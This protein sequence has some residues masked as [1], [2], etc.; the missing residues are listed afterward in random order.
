MGINEKELL[1]SGLASSPVEDIGIDLPSCGNCVICREHLNPKTSFCSTVTGRW[2][3]LPSSKDI[4]LACTTKN[5]VYLITCRVCQFQYVGMTTGSLRQRFYG[6]R[7]SI[8]YAI[9]NIRSNNILLYEH[10]ASYS[11]TLSDVSVQIIY[12]YNGI[13]D[14]ARDV[15]LSVE[16]Y[17]MRVLSTLHPFGFN[18]N[19]TSL[20]INLKDYDFIKFQNMNTPFFSFGNLCK[21]SF[22]SHGHRKHHKSPDLTDIE[23]FIHDIL[24]KY[25]SYEIH[26]IYILLRSKSFKFL[27]YAV[28]HI[29]ATKS[30]TIYKNYIRS[31]NIIYGYFSQYVKI[32]KSGQPDNKVFC[33]IPFLH[34]IVEKINFNRIVND[35]NVRAYLPNPARKYDIQSA[36]SYGP[37]IGSTLFNYNSILHGIDKQYLLND[38]PCDCNTAYAQFVYKP[39]GHVHTGNLEIVTHDGLR[40]IM[41]MGAKFRETPKCSLKKLSVM[42]EGVVERVVKSLACKTHLHIS[43]FTPWK[44]ELLLL[45]LI[46]VTGAF[47]A[48]A[49]IFTL[50]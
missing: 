2:F 34:K 47:L 49:R 7:S 14:N 4:A 45:T 20:N 5:I 33:V 9:K 44:A 1:A 39:H 15:L 12:H 23:S 6:H 25:D 46:R 27:K 42:L 40:R 28:D 3:C 41:K 35:K 22:R 19:I 18:D 13:E 24:V 36:Y 32:K 38:P 16:E 10:F 17:Y 30:S 26:D 50:I 21:R 48:R 31:F 43:A 11:H 29:L 37:T 8:N